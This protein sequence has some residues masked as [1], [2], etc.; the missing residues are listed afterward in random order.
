MRRPP[1][2]GVGGD[3]AYGRTAE[4]GRQGGYGV[5]AAAR[6]APCAE[7]RGDLGGSRVALVVARGRSA[8]G[9][10]PDMLLLLRGKRSRPVNRGGSVDELKNVRLRRFAASHRAP[11][12]LGVDAGTQH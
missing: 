11:C 12:P 2:S 7:E 10:V 4:R 1:G 5:I 6:A 8:G 9:I 3:R